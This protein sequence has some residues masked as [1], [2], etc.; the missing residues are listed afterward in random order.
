MPVKTNTCHPF[1]K[2]GGKSDFVKEWQITYSFAVNTFADYSPFPY[3]PF[4]YSLKTN[5]KGQAALVPFRDKRY[6]SLYK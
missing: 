3:T 5:S 6:F 4:S 1:D 2:K